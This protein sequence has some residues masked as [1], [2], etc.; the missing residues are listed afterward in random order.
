[1]ALELVIRLIEGFHFFGTADLEYMASEKFS[2]SI[3]PG[4]G[5]DVFEGYVDKIKCCLPIASFRVSGHCD[6]GKDKPVV[7]KGCSGAELRVMVIVS[8]ADGILILLMRASSGLYRFCNKSPKLSCGFSESKR[9]SDSLR[10]EGGNTQKQG[11]PTSRQRVQ[12][13]CGH[14]PDFSQP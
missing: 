4:R 6:F 8:L 9:D 5:I 12:A 13:H 11:R 3:L 14:L 1:M 10:V 7:L 2:E